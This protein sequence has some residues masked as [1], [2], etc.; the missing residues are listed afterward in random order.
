MKKFSIKNWKF[1]IGKINII[2]IEIFIQKYNP[3]C[4]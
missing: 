4:I 3:R 1:A 2:F